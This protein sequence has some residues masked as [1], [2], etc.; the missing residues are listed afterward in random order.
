M[1][2]SIK[3][4]KYRPFAVHFVL[5]VV[6]ATVCLGYL[7][8]RTF[9][10]NSRRP[11]YREV[12]GSLSYATSYAPLQ[13]DITTAVS[14]AASVTR[15]AGGCWATGY[16]WRCIFVAM[17]RGGISAKGVSQAISSSLPVLRHSTRKSN[18]AII[19][20][21]LFATFAIDYFSAALTGSF[22]WET[23]DTRIPGKIPLSGVSDGTRAK[24]QDMT[25]EELEEGFVGARTF[26]DTETQMMTMTSASASIAWGTQAQSN[27]ILN[28]TEPSTTFRRVI[29]GAQYISINS[30]LVNVSM[31]YFAL[32]AFEWVRDPYKVLTDKQLSLLNQNAS[33]FNPF[34]VRENGT[35][36]LL[37]DSGV[38]GDGPLA[39]RTDEP[40]SETQLFTFRIWFPNPTNANMVS[41][42]TIAPPCPQN[43]TIDPGSEVN[44]ISGPDYPEGRDCFA[45]ADVS[46]RA[47]EISSQNCKIVS[48]N[49][50]EAQAP[51]SIVG[52]FQSVVALGFAPCIAS[53]F[54]LSNYAI[55]VNYGTNR[56]FAIE[57]TSRAYQA[58]WAAYVDYYT[59]ST[60]VKAVQIALPTL[61]AKI[62][63]SRVYLWA[64]LHLWVLVLGLVFTYIQSH[65]DH[66]WVEDPN[67]AV[68]WLDTRALLTKSDGRLVLDPWQPGTEIRE[69]GM[70]IIE[71]N[72]SAQC[73]VQVKRDSGSRQRRYSDS[74]L[75]RRW[76]PPSSST[77]LREEGR[78]SVETLVGTSIPTSLQP[79]SL[80]STRS[81]ENSA[82]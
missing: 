69:D 16:I 64:A 78:A 76:I 27:S 36:G 2:H 8:G 42:T 67:M 17:E 48:P 52:S 19:Y 56:N 3:F 28:I 26:I 59:I 77:I 30:T 12:D 5:T 71:H 33:G 41:L 53:N 57:L 79:S 49:V 47:G 11:Q 9:N 61:R 32:D 66:P 23:G 60:N 35:G 46:Y 44:F 25:Y 68:F 18:M 22:I 38:W 15:V 74:T 34:L 51:S 20:I 31:P 6:V 13:S 40:I 72:E 1:L 45:I 63:H 62:I 4:C 58:A 37:P 81:P 82:E 65:C 14:L 75:L 55:P 29:N 54:F 10:A 80:D 43:F 70:L 21:T 50:V 24:G 39:Y 7:D 73:S